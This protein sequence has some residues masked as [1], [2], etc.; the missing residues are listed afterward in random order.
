MRSNK[1]YKQRDYTNKVMYWQNQLNQSINCAPIDLDS[2]KIEKALKSLT[3][4]VNKQIEIVK[5]NENEKFQ[6][7]YNAIIKH[8]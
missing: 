4:F 6:E 7:H 1:T 2:A 8:F 5:E 3:Y